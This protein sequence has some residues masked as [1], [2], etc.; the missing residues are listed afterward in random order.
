MLWTAHCRFVSPAGRTPRVVSK[1]LAVIL[2]RFGQRAHRAMK[3]R[4]A[5]RLRQ[6][7]ET[8]AGQQQVL[9]QHRV[10]SETSSC[11]RRAPRREQSA[12]ESWPSKAGRVSRDG[13]GSS[14]NLDSS[15]PHIASS[16]S[17][18]AAR[19]STSCDTCFVCVCVLYDGTPYTHMPRK[20]PP[21]HPFGCTTTRPARSVWWPH[22]ALLAEVE[23]LG[24]CGRR[25]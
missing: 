21:F 14:E 15:S 13:A 24:D 1:F 23:G 10:V 4:Q 11:F 18:S 3:A 5:R 19:A 6:E 16:S 2:P 8:Q 25:L 20:R 22:H 12:A 17:S 7:L 9:A